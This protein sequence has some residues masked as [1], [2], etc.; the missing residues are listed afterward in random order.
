MTAYLWN[1]RPTLFL[2]SRANIE[3]EIA[4]VG[5]QRLA[6]RAGIHPEVP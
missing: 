2:Q 4:N 6:G 3:C 1:V 5:L